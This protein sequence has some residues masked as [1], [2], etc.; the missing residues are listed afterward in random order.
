MYVFVIIC[1]SKEEKFLLSV[2]GL[3]FWNRGTIMM[4]EPKVENHTVLENA[5]CLKLD[6]PL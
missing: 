2:V 4:Q 5:I 1:I 6:I 3:Q